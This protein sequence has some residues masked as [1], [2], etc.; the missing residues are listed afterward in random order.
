MRIPSRDRC[1]PRRMTLP[2]IRH[3]LRRTGHALVNDTWFDTLQVTVV[4]QGVG[5]AV[6]VNDGNRPVRC[7]RSTP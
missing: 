5:G 3:A 1:E 4:T 6:T 2:E 7:P